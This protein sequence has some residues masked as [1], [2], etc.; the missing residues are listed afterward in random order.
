MVRLALRGDITRRFPKI[1]ESTSQ[2]Y[3]PYSIASETRERAA[4]W[5]RL[6]D[7]FSS[8]YRGRNTTGASLSRASS[9]RSTAPAPPRVRIAYVT[10]AT[11][12]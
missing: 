5:N 2:T 12:G 4:A 9:I 11:I 6:Q 8:L 1:C 3:A 7:L 10:G